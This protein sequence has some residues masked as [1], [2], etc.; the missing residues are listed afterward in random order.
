M[1]LKFF[2]K[3]QAIEKINQ[4]VETVND[5]IVQQEQKKIQEQQAKAQEIQNN[6][7][8]DTFQQPSKE[9]FASEGG[10]I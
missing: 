7:P 1:K 2:E 6:Y 5:Y 3:E 9:R 10:R 8:T 4:A